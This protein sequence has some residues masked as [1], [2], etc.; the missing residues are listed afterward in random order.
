MQ[1]VPVVVLVCWKH[2]RV[3]LVVGKTT[4]EISEALPAMRRPT[5]R[6]KSP[7]TEPK[8]SMTRILTNRAESAASATAAVDPVIPTQIPQT[9]LPRPTVRPAQKSEKPVYMFDL[10]YTSSTL[11]S[12]AEKTMAIIRP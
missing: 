12:L 4:Q 1:G 6:P 10:V 8:I 7:R 9:R 3:I 2:T 5:M 11:A